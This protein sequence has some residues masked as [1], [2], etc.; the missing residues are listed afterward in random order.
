MLAQGQLSS[1][2]QPILIIPDEFKQLQVRSILLFNSSEQDT[3]RLK[4]YAVPNDSLSLG[5]VGADKQFLNLELRPE[6]IFEFTTS[7]PITYNTIN[8]AIFGEATNANEINYFINGT[9]S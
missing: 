2:P 7:F 3:N 9:M 4:L 1:T 8:D 6:Q 5:I